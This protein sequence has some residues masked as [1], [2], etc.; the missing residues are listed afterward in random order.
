MGRQKTKVHFIFAQ[1]DK[2]PKAREFNRKSALEFIERVGGKHSLIYESCEG[3]N[4]EI[5]PK[6]HLERLEL[7]KLNEKNRRQFGTQLDKDLKALKKEM[8]KRMNEK[9]GRGEPFL[10]I[11]YNVGIETELLEMNRTQNGRI[12]FYL[13][14]EDSETSFA[15]WEWEVKRRSGESN[16]KTESE[17]IK[18]LVKM[19]LLRDRKLIDKIGKL[20]REE[21][22]RSIIITRGTAHNKM[23]DIIDP[24]QFEITKAVI[25][26]HFDFGDIALFNSYRGELSE[27]VI[28]KLAKLQIA[29][30]KEWAKRKSLFGAAVDLVKR[31]VIPNEEMHLHCRKTALKEEGI[32]EEFA[33]D[34]KLQFEELIKRLKQK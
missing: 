8:E 13:E 14:P 9:R 2:S 23:V 21:R 24:D 16:K 5:A 25:G 20:A 32:P 10:A 34:E 30:M 12:K 29:H 3:D 19:Q 27:E 17:Y 18:S 11:A 7:L 31:R 15:Q 33:Y 4:L 22:E 26:D 28:E 1:H 6:T